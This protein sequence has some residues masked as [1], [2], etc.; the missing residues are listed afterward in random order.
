M[1]L[2]RHDTSQRLSAETPV[3]GIAHD[4]ALL[5]EPTA[6][7]WWLPSSKAVVLGLG[8]RHRVDRVIDVERCQR[9][10]VAVLDR[11]AGGGAVFL[12]RGNMLCGAVVVPTASVPADV[13]ESYR[14]LGDTLVTALLG[15]GVPAQRVEVDTARAD[16]ATSPL[17]NACYGALSP[18]EVTVNGRKL[19]G[20]AQIRRRDTTLYVLGILLQDQSPLADYLLV[21]DESVRD[22]LRAELVKRTI[23]LESLTSRSASEVVAAVADAMPSAQ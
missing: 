12:D 8:L 17:V 2:P 9:A 11:R 23:G 5:D 20:L 21:P 7:H 13:T 15:L 3:E 10:G 18:H 14:W 22:R 6:V 16:R 4:E 19:V 1:R